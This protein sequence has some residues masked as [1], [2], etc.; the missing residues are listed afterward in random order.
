MQEP[1]HYRLIKRSARKF[2]ALHSATLSY[3]DLDEIASRATPYFLSC[4][5]QSRIDDTDKR[6]AIAAH[7][8]AR[9]AVCQYWSESRIGTANDNRRL[10][11]VDNDDLSELFGQSVECKPD[12]SEKMLAKLNHRQR[13]VA[14]GFIRGDSWEFIANDAKYADKSGLAK[15]VKAIR[16]RLADY[17]PDRCAMDVVKTAL[18]T[19]NRYAWSKWTNGV[20]TEYWT[21]ENN[22][23]EQPEPQERDNDNRDDAP[24]PRRAKDT[25][26]VDT[27]IP[28][29]PGEYRPMQFDPPAQHLP[30]LPIM[31]HCCRLSNGMVICG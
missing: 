12:N 6:M 22:P 5:M 13:I 21:I 31:P 29:S 2:A 18:E 28:A 10:K 24:R 16:K 20:C 30:R 23:Q 14:L 26:Q 8:S 4:W 27:A 15:C 7:R 11:T 17:D 25:R 1:K 9:K 19:C 3:S